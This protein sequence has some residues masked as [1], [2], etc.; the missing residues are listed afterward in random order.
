VIVKAFEYRGN[1]AEEWSNKYWFTAP[2]PVS[3]AGWKSFADAVIAE[4]KICYSPHSSVV[5][6]YAY[7]DNTPDAHSIWSY[8]YGLAG[9]A[10]AGTLVGTEGNYMAGDQA[11]LCQWKTERRNS[12]GKAIWLRKFFHSGFISPADSDA[13]DLPTQT[14]Y[15]TFADRM[16][17]PSVGVWQ[18]IRSQA[19][20]EVLVLQGG[21]GWVTTRT[22]KKRGKKKKTPPETLS[23]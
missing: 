20:E 9:E 17:G 14:A 23:A 3:S 6:A 11:G 10:V 21:S 19:Q 12:K 13:I 16:A 4:E 18:K 2:V 5:R 8:D 7:D 1:S 15:Q 22:L